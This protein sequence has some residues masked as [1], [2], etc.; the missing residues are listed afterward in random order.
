MDYQKAANDFFDSTSTHI[1]SVYE[2]DH[3]KIM[4]NQI[5]SR[6]QTK[7][8][9]FW[10]D[11][12]VFT[13]DMHLFVSLS[14]AIARGVQIRIITEDWGGLAFFK[15]RGIN[16]MMAEKSALSNTNFNFIVADTK[17]FRTEVLEDKDKQFV[18]A[19]DP[20][21]AEKIHTLF[22]KEWEMSLTVEKSVV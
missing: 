3:A 17:M 18:A 16:F 14:Q 13:E 7:I 2:P 11:W 10:K 12:L 5:I 1:V 19:N 8:D 9:I 4:I 20:E 15:N 21:L 6:A 22:D